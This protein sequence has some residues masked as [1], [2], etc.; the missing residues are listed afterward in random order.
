MIAIAGYIGHGNVRKQVRDD[1]REQAVLTIYDRGVLIGKILPIFEG[2]LHTKKKRIQFL[3]W[4]KDL[5]QPVGTTTMDPTIIDPQWLV[6]FT[7]GDG[8]FY[9]IIHTNKSYVCG[10]QVQLVFDIAQEDKEKEVLIRIGDQHFNGEYTW[11]L[12]KNSQHLRIT[13]KSTI[14]EY[15]N[16]FFSRY[17]LK[18][19][20][21]V[22]FTIWQEMLSLVLSNKHLTTEGVD[23]IRDL[24]VIQNN[25]RS[26]KGGKK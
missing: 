24:V 7:D 2:R 11:A 13:K 8:S 5:G 14:V 17:R 26:G 19:R 23:R 4:K 15:V 6:G 9:P 1:G 18:T 25:N 12:S 16:P 20:K 21:G 22:D 3:N 10:Y